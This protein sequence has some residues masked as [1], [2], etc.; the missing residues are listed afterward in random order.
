MTTLTKLFTEKPK[1]VTTSLAF[2]DNCLFE[3]KKNRETDFA[4]VEKYSLQTVYTLV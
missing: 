1:F 4:H 3:E 2:P